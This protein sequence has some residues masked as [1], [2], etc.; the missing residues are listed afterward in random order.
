MCVTYYFVVISIMHFRLWMTG[1]LHRLKWQA[2][3]SMNA[4]LRVSKSTGEIMFE[5]IFQRVTMRIHWSV[6]MKYH[7]GIYD[8]IVSIRSTFIVDLAYE[9]RANKLS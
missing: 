8:M 7:C 9:M 6:L 5:Q 4:N 1:G 3:I 2:Y